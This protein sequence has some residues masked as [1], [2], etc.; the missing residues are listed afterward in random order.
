MICYFINVA[1]YKSQTRI[2]LLEQRYS[3]F[4]KSIATPP[5]FRKR[6]QNPALNLKQKLKK[7]TISKMKKT[8]LSIG[9]LFCCRK[10]WSGEKNHS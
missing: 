9:F 2:A 7:K 1:S 3:H 8:A 6:K 5:P 4:H 10:L